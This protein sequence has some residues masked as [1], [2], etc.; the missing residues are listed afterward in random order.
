MEGNNEIKYKISPKFNFIYELGM[1]TGKKIRN[2][3]VVLIVFIILSFASL[4][5]SPMISTDGN[6]LLESSKISNI[7]KVICVIATIVV[8]VKFIIDLII[9]IMQYK[10]LTYTFY[11]EIMVYED[12]FLNQHRKTVAYK[13]IK[14]VEIRRTIWDRLL[15]FGIIIIHTNAE[16]GRG[17]GIVI[18]GIKDPKYHYDIIYNIIHSSNSGLYDNSDF[19]DT[20]KNV[21]SVSSNERNYGYDKEREFKDEKEFSDYLKGSNK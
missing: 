10:H 18:Y 4:A 17:N 1:P 2:D 12:D 21:E 7:A 3:I 16:N 19:I 15:N 14:E 5:F 6:A 11:D 20:T 8:A 13:N 9:Q